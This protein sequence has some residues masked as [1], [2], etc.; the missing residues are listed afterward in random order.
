M[1]PI[2]AN[3]AAA[4]DCTKVSVRSPDTEASTD[5]IVHSGL[6]LGSVLIDEMSGQNST[7]NNSVELHVAELRQ[8]FDAFDPGPGR[9]P[10][11]DARA[12]EFIVERSRDVASLGLLVHLDRAAGLEDE[13]AVLQEAVHRHF[14]E[15]AGASRRRLKNLLRVGRI[16]VLIGLGF[17]A[18]V[19]GAGEML[20]RSAYDGA[21]FV[22]VRETI[23]IGGWVAMWRP[24]EIFL[25]DWWPIRAE[26]RLFDRL[27]AMPVR[28]HYESRGSSDAWL[29]DWPAAEPLH[30]HGRLDDGV[31]IA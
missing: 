9:E 21:I 28:I 19:V 22:A 6:V 24:L 23:L 13:Q 18:A 27:A 14:R 20:E 30:A 25:Y 10:D 15:R 29:G 31:G 7:R 3:T 5:T 8:L 26:A 16:S 4:R 2:K 17:L 11:L 12:H 1:S